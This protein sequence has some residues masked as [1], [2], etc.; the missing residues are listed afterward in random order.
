SV[1]N[2]YL[3]DVSTDENRKANFGKL[4]ASTSLGF[5]IGPVLAGVLG[6]T[7][8]GE[9]LPV[10]AAALI[11]LVAIAVIYFYLPES[12]PE[13]VENDLDTPWYHKLFGHEHKDC[14]ERTCAEEGFG[15]TQ[16]LRIEGVAMLFLIYFLTFFGF[17]FFYSGFPIFASGE[18]DWT[19]FDLGIFFAVSSTVMIL[20]QG[21]LLSYLSKRVS[22]ERLVTVGTLI[23][24]TSFF[25]FPIGTSFSAYAGIIL[26]SLGNG[27]MWPSFLSIL[28]R[29]GPKNRQ[30][31]LQGYA[32]S[33]GSLAGIFGLV[34]GGLLYATF[35]PQVF[36]VGGAIIILIFLLSFRLPSA[37][38]VK[39]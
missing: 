7:A 25:M 2:A 15:L 19:S 38:Q 22:D 4:G 29:T 11:S 9:L 8:L 10:M 33:M 18:L 3:S 27:L 6:A 12:R 39:A 37:T 17:S 20:T 26:L 30:G 35:G 16:V 36:Y 5:V 21:P 14:F 23:L 13:L 34:G 32:N 1:A 28:G 31:S 24:A